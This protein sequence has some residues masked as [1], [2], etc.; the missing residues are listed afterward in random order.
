MKVLSI[1]S[2]SIYYQS[3]GKIKE[4][5]RSEVRNY[6]LSSVTKKRLSSGRSVEGREPNE[7]KIMLVAGYAFSNPAGDYGNDNPYDEDA[8]MAMNGRLLQAG[9]VLKVSKVIGVQAWYRHMQNPFNAAVFNSALTANVGFPLT[10]T[11]SPWKMSGFFGG[12]CLRLPV[13]GA[14]QVKVLLDL[15]LG[16]PNF[17]FPTVTT[18]VNGGLGSARLEGSKPRAPAWNMGGGF[19]F[20]VSEA[21]GLRV[22]LNYLQTTP[23]FELRSFANGMLVDTNTYDQ[24]IEALNIGASFVIQLGTK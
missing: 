20:S 3:G 24:H 8:G 17:S 14:E 18:V 6:I 10:T 1:D 22:F 13:S 12:L 4:V 11:A 16:I 23:S 9:I 19:E 2:S 5:P 21:V 7:E 15:D